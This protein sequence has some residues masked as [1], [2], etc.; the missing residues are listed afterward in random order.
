VSRRRLWSLTALVCA[1]LTVPGAVSAR[2]ELV[3]LIGTTVR[4]PDPQVA[5]ALLVLGAAAVT[6]GLLLL[7]RSPRARPA[8]VLA[9][10]RRGRGVPEIARRTRLAQ[11]AVRDVAGVAPR[12]VSTGRWGRIFRRGAERVETVDETFEELLEQSAFKA[13]T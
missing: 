8:V 13:N 12:A 3:A 6:F 9:M 4:T 11:D 5:M 1:L 2:P 10:S 7:G